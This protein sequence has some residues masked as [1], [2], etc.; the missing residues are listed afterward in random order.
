M[1][2]KLFQIVDFDDSFTL[3]IASFL[4]KERFSF[5]VINWKVWRGQVN[6]CP[7]TLLGPGPGHVREYESCFPNITKLLN[8]EDCFVMGICLGHQLIHYVLDYPIIPWTKPIHGQSRLLSGQFW[9]WLEGQKGINKGREIKWR[10]QFY[11]SWGVQYKSQGLSSLYIDERGQ[12]LS[13]RGNHHLSYQFHP[14]SVGTTF[15][16]RLFAPVIEKLDII[17]TGYDVSN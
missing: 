13:G 9:S 5:Q 6:L 4:A 12:V 11:N 10:A 15:P 17:K 14:E 1:N 7:F 2:F 3:N 8:S 16:D